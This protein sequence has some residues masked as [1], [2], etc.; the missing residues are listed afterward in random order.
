MFKRNVFKP[1]ED[2]YVKGA[3]RE[4]NKAL[5]KDGY[6]LLVQNLSSNVMDA[7]VTIGR[8]Y[9]NREIIKEEV[10]LERPF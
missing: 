8:D 9:H 1:F 6:P 2:T 5:A 7:L 10:D 4:L 3:F